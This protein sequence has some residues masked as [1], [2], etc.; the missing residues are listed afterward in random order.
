[1]S[2]LTM[3]QV[4]PTPSTAD[5]PFDKTL[6]KF[7]TVLRLFYKVDHMEIYNDSKFP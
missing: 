4:T 3:D 1:M 6:S 7:N 2:G 5:C